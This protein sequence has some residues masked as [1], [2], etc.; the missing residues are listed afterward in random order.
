MEAHVIEREEFERRGLAARVGDHANNLRQPGGSNYD[1]AVLHTSLGFCGLSCFPMTP[2]DLEGTEE[3]TSLV[4]GG[5][6]EALFADHVIREG[7][8]RAAGYIVRIPS[9]RH[10]GH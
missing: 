2:A 10:G 3:T 4:A 1:F 6:F 8:C 7:T 9:H 5:R